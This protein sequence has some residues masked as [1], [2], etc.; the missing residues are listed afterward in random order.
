MKKKYIIIFAFV[1]LVLGN[2]IVF[3]NED[4]S[5]NNSI[6]RT[7][8]TKAGVGD[9]IS[10]IFLDPN[11]AKKIANLLT[12][13]DV[14][15]I[16]TQEMVD[17]TTSL[18]LTN[19]NITDLTGVGIFANVEIFEA[20][21][22]KLDKLTP[23]I[24]NL[25][26]LT[27]LT[28]IGS[29]ITSIPEEIGQLSNLTKLELHNNNIASIPET[30][31]NL[32]N[33]DYLTLSNNKL[34]VLPNS[35]G[36]LSKLRILYANNN[37]LNN[38]PDEFC[39]LESISEIVVNNNKINVL[40]ECIG[41]LSNLSRFNLRYNELN[42]IPES[43]GQLSKIVTLEL[44]DN[45]ITYIPDSISQIT[46]LENVYLSL[47]FLN[48][49]PNGLLKI[50]N[51][52]VL[53]LD[54]NNITKI[55][56]EITQL[57]NLTNIN[58][59]SNPIKEIPEYFWNI[60]T[61]TRLDISS[62]GLTNL[63]D[64]FVNLVNLETAILDNNLL[65]TLPDNLSQ[66]SKIRS[67]SIKN[68]QLT[69]LPEEFITFYKLFNTIKLSGN[70]LPTN[71]E[72]YIKENITV[73]MNV[74]REVQRQLVIDENAK[75]LE[76]TNINEFNNLNLHTQ[77]KISDDSISSISHNL[78]LEN[79][80]DE[81][82][83]PVDLNQFYTDGVVT[84][85]GSIYAQIR[86]TGKGIYL[87]TSENALTTNKIRIDF[88]I[89]RYSLQFNLNDDNKTIIDTQQLEFNQLANH[90]NNPIRDGYTFK[91]WN[92]KEDGSGVYWDFDSSKMSDVDVVLYAQ[93]QKG[94]VIPIDK[95]DNNTSSGDKEI[96]N[97][98]KSTVS[99]L[100]LPATGI[101][102][103]LS[104]MTFIMLVSIGCIFSSIKYNK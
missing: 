6:S 84:K 17:S 59:A 94:E 73:A 41:N 51:L 30:I 9:K 95:I 74:T 23:D 61:L 56:K 31:G 83:N 48:E 29:N 12:K 47:N 86:A 13:G 24:A 88:K 97:V 60:K 10:E 32:S 36:N 42:T 92:T 4:N 69:S 75:V 34:D 80:V 77:V 76:V 93:W 89:K 96:N 46:N 21:L 38:L 50:N 78:E 37:N 28:L 65:T 26:K 85:E 8:Q 91:G 79:I 22:N 16:L 2:S 68:N 100:C 7:I 66:L 40:P 25:T 98:S 44:V 18:S 82:N 55:P 19:A 3:A 87:N 70:L 54:S 101:D 33:L 53:Y 67:F 45:K 104:V 52:K 81:N 90:V 20:N 27:Q 15:A 62:I 5:K 39:N 72:E 43:F 103:N 64:K 14:D 58:I 1:L 57:P 71:Y 11:L 102:L 35:M 99:K 49:I 63:S